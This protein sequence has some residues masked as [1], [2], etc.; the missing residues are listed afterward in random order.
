[1]SA[2]PEV[3]IVA[4]GRKRLWPRP[5]KRLRPSR[6]RADTGRTVPVPVPAPVGPRHGRTVPVPAPVGNRRRPG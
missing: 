4:R 3:A 1:M 5:H 6:R 2:A